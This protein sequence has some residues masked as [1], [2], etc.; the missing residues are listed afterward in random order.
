MLNDPEEMRWGYDVFEEAAG[1]LM[2]IAETKVN[3]R[4]MNRDFFDKMDEI[5]APLQ[6]RF[7][8]FVSCFSRQGD[9]PS[10]WS[11]YADDEHGFAIGFAARALMHMPISM[12][13]VEYDRERQVQEMMDALGACFLENEAD[14]GRFGSKF[15]ESCV[16]IGSFMI[17]FK[18]PKF[19]EEREI[20]CLHATNPVRNKN[21]MWLADRDGVLG[22]AENVDGEIVHFRVLD[23]ALVAYFDMPFRRGFE[24]TPIKRIMLDPKNPNWPANILYF[25]GSLGYE[26]VAIG[27][28]ITP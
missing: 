16:V 1:K 12:L 14:G 11:T 18:N 26:D 3:L 15:F 9:L 28:S 2:K 4:N 21:A 8:P 25:T 10:Q 20:R 6:G 24:K 27:K 19:R 22:G 23:N 5:I 17:A 13:I 7:H